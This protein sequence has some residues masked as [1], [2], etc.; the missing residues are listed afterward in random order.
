[1]NNMNKPDIVIKKYCSISLHGDLYLSFCLK[2]IIAQ[3]R[4]IIFLKNVSQLVITRASPK[5][6]QS[7][8][9]FFKAINS[10]KGVK[11][12]MK[13]STALDV[14]LILVL[15]TSDKPMTNSSAESN[16]ENKN[17][18]ELSQVNDRALK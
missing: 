11:I 5:Q 18:V 1:M 14:H 4:R 2:V 9:G 17:A 16:I 6:P 15:K 8:T 12:L 10:V 7:E 3:A 13:I